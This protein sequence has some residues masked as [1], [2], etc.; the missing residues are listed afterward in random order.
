[1]A[2]ERDDFLPEFDDN[3]EDVLFQIQMKVYNVFMA[4]WKNLLGISVIFLLGVLVQGLYADHKQQE[5][6]QAHGELLFVRSDL[7]EPD[8]I[9]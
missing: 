5:Q 6:R 2:E 8:P 4:H 1:M 7:P 9:D 3:D